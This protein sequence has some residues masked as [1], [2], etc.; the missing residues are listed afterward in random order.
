MFEF[1]KILRKRTEYIS[2][3]FLRLKR[4][5]K[6][7]CFNDT[8]P[9]CVCILSTSTKNDVWWVKMNSAFFRQL[10]MFFIITSVIEEIL[11]RTKMF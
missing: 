2:S 11:K 1:L 9:P 7:K 10:D 5:F 3:I 6:A 8:P 4:D